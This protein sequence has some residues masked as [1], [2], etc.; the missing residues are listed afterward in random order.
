VRDG[1]VADKTKKTNPKPL[2]TPK[3]PTLSDEESCTLADT[4]TFLTGVRP[5]EPYQTFRLY[6]GKLT[7]ARLAL[8]MWWAFRVSN[9]WSRPE[10]WLVLDLENFLNASGK[11]EG[12]LMK[13]RQL[14]GLE[15]KFPTAQSVHDFLIPPTPEKIDHCGHRWGVDLT[16]P[17]R[18]C[19]GCNL[20][21]QNWDGKTPCPYPD[22]SPALSDASISKAWEIEVEEDH[23]TVSEAFEVEED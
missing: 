17:D 18:D 9:F 8:L 20:P 7:S 21:Y 19:E 23:I 15:K 10:N 14:P 5:P 2:G 1:C 6:T 3:T 11:I 13:W 16:N 4:F 12:Q 22:G